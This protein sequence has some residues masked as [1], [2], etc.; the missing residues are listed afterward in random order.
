MS[1][2]SSI[3]VVRSTFLDE[4]GPPTLE[5]KLKLRLGLGPTNP[6]FG[7]SLHVLMLLTS[8][9]LRHSSG[10]VTDNGT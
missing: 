4:T 7:H 5:P 6:G 2:P 8:M 9:V 1:G 10:L 3:K